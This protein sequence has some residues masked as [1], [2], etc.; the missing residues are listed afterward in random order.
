MEGQEEKTI[1]GMWVRQL[2]NDPSEVSRSVQLLR[3]RDVSKPF[4]KVPGYRKYL[5]GTIVPGHFVSKNLGI[6]HGSSF[7]L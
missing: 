3:A 5:G 1:N 7:W 4:N 2:S 6:V